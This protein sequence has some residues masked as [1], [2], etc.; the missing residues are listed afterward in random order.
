MR[1]DDCSAPQPLACRHLTPFA[2]EVVRGG[3]ACRVGHTS[4]S[5]I[6]LC[7]RSFYDHRIYVGFVSDFKIS[8]AIDETLCDGADSAISQC[9]NADWPGC[10]VNLI[11]KGLNPK[12]LPLSCT[13]DGALP[14][15]SAPCEPWHRIDVGNSTSQ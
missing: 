7:S 5:I 8:G 9:D 12:R 4:R 3:A 10:I 15:E 1:R 13:V 11:G 2:T 14:Q 6:R